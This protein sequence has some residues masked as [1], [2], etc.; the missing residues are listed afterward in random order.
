MQGAPDLWETMEVQRLVEPWNASEAQN[1]IEALGAVDAC[2]ARRCGKP[3]R[4]LG[5]GKQRV[6][7]RCRHGKDVGGAGSQG[8]MDPWVATEAQELTVGGE[9]MER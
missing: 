6:R 9:V 7:T 3:L 5:C 1:V 4:S 2:G 8:V